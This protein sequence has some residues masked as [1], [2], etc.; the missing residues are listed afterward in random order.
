MRTAAEGE[1]AWER[2]EGRELFELRELREAR[3]G[4]PLLEAAARVARMVAEY[5]IAGLGEVPGPRRALELKAGAEAER[6]LLDVAGLNPREAGPAELQEILDEVRVRLHQGAV[7][8]RVRVVSPYRLRARRVSH[9]F[10]ASLQDGEFPRR[11]PGSPL[12]GDERRRELGL[13]ERASSEDEERYLF[14]VCLSRP[15]Q[16]LALSW[17]YAN[18]E[19]RALARSPFVDDVRDLLAPEQPED[20]EATDPL[21][22]AI[23]HERGPADVVPAPG[24]ASS[25]RELARAVALSGRERWS[26]GL[27]ALSV[28]D[29]AGEAVRAFLGSAEETTDPARMAPRDLRSPSV[30]GELGRRELFGASTLEEYE[31][32]SYRWFVSHELRPRRL[33]PTDEPLVLGGLAHKVLEVLFRERPGGTPRPTPDTLDEWRRRARELVQEHAAESDLPASD[34]VAFA[35]MRR[36]EGLISAHLADEAASDRVLAPDPELLEAAFG[37]EEDDQRP[38]LELDGLRLHGKI[39]RVDTVDLPGGRAGLISDYKLSR[40]VTAAAKLSEKGKLQLQLYSL[41]LERLWRIEPLGGVYLPLRGTTS[42]RPRG[43]MDAE[44]SELLAGLDTFGNDLLPHDE[45]EQA[46]QGAAETASR[47]AR[48]IHEGHLRRNPLGGECPRFCRFQ[49]ICRRE[50]GMNEDDDPP[51]EEDE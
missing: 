31:T 13:A 3:A 33:D 42:R 51:E 34:P 39:D 11:D 46:L 48:D 36:V 50:R 29:E 32:C 8:G 10:V 45:F 20:P 26:D 22:E 28:P 38:S 5:P 40:E 9:L 6:A 21:F 24:E 7:H 27:A 49:T 4:R 25:R 15:E 30:L 14:A 16:G 37:D 1:A 2:Q 18:D 41:A 19:G 12:L 23:G 47:I 17:R 44:H 35:Q 43:V